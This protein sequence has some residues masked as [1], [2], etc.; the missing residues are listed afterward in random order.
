MSRFSSQRASSH[1]SFGSPSR[2]NFTVSSNQAPPLNSSPEI[3]L[4]YENKKIEH[5]ID[6]LY[7]EN[8]K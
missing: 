1:H 6:K 7:Q 2:H 5:E 4:K 3:K 8:N